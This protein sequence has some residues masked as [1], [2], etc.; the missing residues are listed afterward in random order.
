MSMEQE[1]KTLDLA[2]KEELKVIK[3]KYSSLKSDVKK[4]YK[5]LE[6][7][8]KKQEKEEIKKIR[9]SIPKSLKILVWDKNIGKEK[10]IGKCDVCKC[11]IDSKNFECGHIISVKDGG[12]TNI[13][14]LLPICSSCNKSMG[15]QNLIEFKDTYFKVNSVSI[16]KTNPLTP[17]EEYIETQLKYNEELIDEELENPSNN[18]SN[19]GND[20][21]NDMYGIPSFSKI[22]TGRKIKRK[23]TIDDIYNHYR[24]WLSSV[25]VEEYNKICIFDYGCKDELIELMTKK[26][27]D[28][29]ISPGDICHSLSLIHVWE[30][31]ELC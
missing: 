19:Y 3:D 30:N 6:K 4:K 25:Y 24:K 18:F 10:G 11:D 2:M 21:V 28:P 17:M 7:Q 23:I 5:E 13:N 8:R 27:G 12:E 20:A 1:I 26:Y 31:I 15:T 29:T 16:H 9:K 14:N 22:K